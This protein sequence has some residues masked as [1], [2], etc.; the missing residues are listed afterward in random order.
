VLSHEQRRL[1]RRIHVSV[2]AVGIALAT[3]ISYSAYP[4]VGWAV[5]HGIGNWFYVIYALWQGTAAFET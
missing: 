1:R 5:M 3:A 2:T 4:S